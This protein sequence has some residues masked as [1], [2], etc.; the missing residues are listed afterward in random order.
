VRFLG[1]TTPDRALQLLAA[2][3]VVA[4]PSR[5]E[6]L[7]KVCVEATAVGT[8]FVVT[9]TTGIA[10]WAQRTGIGVV[11]PACDP[12]ALAAGIIDALRRPP[13]LSPER[14]ASFVDLFSPRTVAAA[15]IEFYE[16]M[17]GRR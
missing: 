8:P 16:E 12:P 11:A 1:G 4:V 15:V 13:A 5:L 10:H 7:N 9:E 3:D 2:A 14:I 17:L 6:S